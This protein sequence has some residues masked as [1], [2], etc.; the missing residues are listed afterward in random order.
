MIFYFLYYENR[1][2]LLSISDNA[3]YINVT[4]PFK[5]NITILTDEVSPENYFQP[6]YSSKKNT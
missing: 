2:K 6:G 5:L 4:Y 3:W 1:L